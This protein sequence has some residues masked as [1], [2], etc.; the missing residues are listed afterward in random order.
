VDALAA[1][2]SGLLNA[3]DRASARLTSALGAVDGKLAGLL[4]A[5]ADGGQQQSSRVFSGP[6]ASA[7][8]KGGGVGAAAAQARGRLAAAVAQ[9]PMV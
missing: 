7:G 9:L 2:R 6:G 3:F 1:G 8:A 5:P 4:H